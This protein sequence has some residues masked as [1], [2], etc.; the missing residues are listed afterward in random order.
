M[1]TGYK[2]GGYGL[3]DSEIGVVLMAAAMMELL[4]Q[5]CTLWHVDISRAH[6]HY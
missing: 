1:V 6:A 3:D 2:D 5:A 4:C